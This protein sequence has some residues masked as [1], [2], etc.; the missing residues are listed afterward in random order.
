MSMNCTSRPDCSCNFCTRLR[1]K[2]ASGKSEKEEL[3]RAAED[4]LRSYPRNK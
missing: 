3:N 1:E 4:F 2:H